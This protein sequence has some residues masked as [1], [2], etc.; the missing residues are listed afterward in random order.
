M[1]FKVIK[2]LVVNSIDTATPHA[3]SV[4]RFEITPKEM[5]SAVDIRKAVGYR[6]I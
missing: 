6:I 1:F 3:L 2:I 4:T 5:E